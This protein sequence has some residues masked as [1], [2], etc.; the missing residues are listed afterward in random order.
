KGVQKQTVLSAGISG[1]LTSY[2]VIS[3]WA[4]QG[5]GFAIGVE[6]RREKLRFEADALAQ[7]KGTLESRGRIKVEEVY[8]ELEVPLLAD[9]PLIKALNVNAGYRYSRY[10]N[11]G[12]NGVVTKYGASTYK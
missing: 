3:P 5:V 6:Q 9:L 12:E 4:T 10:T 8:G 7:A 1:D 11:D 2:G